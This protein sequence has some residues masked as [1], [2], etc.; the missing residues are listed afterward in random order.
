MFPPDIPFPADCY[1]QALRELDDYKRKIALSC[2]KIENL[3]SRS[4]EAMTEVLALLARID[5]LLTRDRTPPL[6]RV[7]PTMTFGSACCFQFG[8]RVC[9]THTIHRAGVF[10]SL[11]TL[12]PPVRPTMPACRR[13]LAAILTVSPNRSE[14]SFRA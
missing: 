8:P 10:F 6:G 7:P 13:V 3:V 9:P 5:A 11:P 1:K 12:R 4:K 14:G 2:S